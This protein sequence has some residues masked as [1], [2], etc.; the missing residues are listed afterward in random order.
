MELAVSACQGLSCS[1]GRPEGDSRSRAV[2]PQ[3][4]HRHG[5]G[6]LPGG[7]LCG[8]HSRPKTGEIVPDLRPYPR[9]IE[10]RHC[11]DDLHAGV[12]LRHAILRNG[13]GPG[14]GIHAHRLVLRSE[15]HTSELQSPCNLVCRLLLE[16]KKKTITHECAQKKKKQTKKKQ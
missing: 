15:E 13:C 8:R 6:L 12:R 3:L 5:N 4:A 7:P 1:A 2:R 10:I 11:C 14:T 9:P 16:K